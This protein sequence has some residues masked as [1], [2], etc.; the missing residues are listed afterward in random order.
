MAG[1]DELDPEHRVRVLA[2]AAHVAVLAIEAGDGDLAPG[3]RR[4]R[5]TGRLVVARPRPAV[6]QPRSA[7]SSSRTSATPPRRNGR[8]Q[9]GGARTGASSRGLAW[10]WLGQ[11]RVLLDDLDGAADALERGSVEV[12]PGGDMSV[13]SLALLASVRHLRDE[14][15]AALAAATE[16]VDRAQSYRR[17]ASGPGSCTRHCPTP[18]SWV[19]ADATQKLS[20][21]SLTCSRTTLFRRRPG[22]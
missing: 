20:T 13:V 18:S 19:I 16:V 4:R 12:V 5:R 7:A 21:S 6:P 9:G 1:L 8:P 2:V 10:F 15:E 17:S 22:S 11:A 3:G 14:H